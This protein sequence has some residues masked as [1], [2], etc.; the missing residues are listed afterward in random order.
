MGDEF[1]E[2]PASAL[3]GGLIG[4]AALEDVE[5][6]ATSAV[7]SVPRSSGPASERFKISSLPVK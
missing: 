3:A 7:F 5:V 4:L 2:Q 1:I 6:G